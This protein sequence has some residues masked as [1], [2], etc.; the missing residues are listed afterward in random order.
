MKT[1]SY[2]KHGYFWWVRCDWSNRSTH[3]WKSC[4]SFLISCIKAS[5]RK[6]PFLLVPGGEERGETDVFAGYIKARTMFSLRLTQTG[7]LSMYDI[8]R[9]STLTLSYRATR[10]WSDQKYT[11]SLL[12]SWR[13]ARKVQLCFLRDL[14]FHLQNCRIQQEL[15]ETHKICLWLER[16]R[17][18]SHKEFA[19][20]LCNSTENAWNSQNLAS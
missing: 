4:F 6:H 14:A 15:H 17:R 10:S 8:K 18:G 13:S 11:S 19:Y 20:L 9:N 12:S 16:V 1:Q 3:T 5:L 7:S 2:R